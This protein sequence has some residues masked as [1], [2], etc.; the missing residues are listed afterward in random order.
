MFCLTSVPVLSGVV[1][2][3]FISI[4]V[5]TP[6]DNFWVVPLVHTVSHM[7]PHTLLPPASDAARPMWMHLTKTLTC[8]TPNNLSKLHNW[9]T[10]RRK[11]PAMAHAPLLLLTMISKFRCP[12][13]RQYSVSGTF[14]APN[15]QI[16]DS[17]WINTSFPCI[18]RLLSNFHVR[19]VALFPT[20]P[21][22]SS[23][24]S[25]LTPRLNKH[26]FNI[27]S[28]ALPTKLNK[29]GNVRIT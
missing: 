29:T 4:V 9:P 11:K 2:K 22:L 25:I 1:L 14:Y 13:P 24:L 5:L 18:S 10:W 23:F 6:H 17:G 26:N 7:V 20:D 15:A 12:D 21:L 28:P 8:A 16:Y 19:M 27:P 3:F